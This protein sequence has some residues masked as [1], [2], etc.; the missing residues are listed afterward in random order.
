MRYYTD[1][2]ECILENGTKKTDRTGVGTI[3]YFAPP[4]MSFDLTKGFP[5]VTTK[6]VPF[7]SVVAEL[8]WILEGS[9]D[10]RRLAE[11]TYGKSREELLDKKTIWTEN[12]DAQGVQK[13]HKNTDTVKEL[14]P[15]YGQQLRNFNGFDQLKYVVD[16]VKNEP[17]SRRI[18]F[19]YWNPSDLETA[20]L[21]PCHTLF[22]MNVTNGKLSGKL[23]MRSNDVILGAPFNIVFYS[24]LLHIIAAECGLDVG[25][26]THS[27]GDAHIYQNHLEG[28]D[29][30]LTRSFYDLPEL[31]IDTR[32]GGEF[33]DVVY[34]GKQFSNTAASYFSLKNYQHHPPIKLPMAV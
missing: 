2:I 10:E 26:Y 17:D 34:N 18:L 8:L 1:F 9:T 14:G 5:I 31:E 4:D 23:Y 12:A 32:F 6:K 24:L 28:V 25:E 33:L 21:P 27:V 11:L 3:S 19:S 29:E 22:Q 20:A 13:G 30:I 7:K 16:L 15:V